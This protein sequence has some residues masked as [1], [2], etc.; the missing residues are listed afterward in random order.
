[1]FK[2]TE[3]SNITG[4]T[5]R[6][7]QYYDEIG[8]LVPSRGENGHRSYSYNDLI[9]V[10][11]IILLKDMGFKLDEIIKHISTKENKELK[12]SLY[13]QRKILANKIKE[14]ESQLRNIDW[15]IQVNEKKQTLEE[16]AIK[17]VFIDNN[18]FKK[19]IPSIWDM[20]I[21]DTYTLYNLKNY[22][23]NMNFDLYFKKLAK[24]Q[25][26]NVSEKVVQ[27]LIER[28]VTHL[29]ESY[30]ESFSNESIPNFA[31]LYVENEEAIEYLEQ[32]GSEFNIFLNRA[33]M[34]Y[35][36]ENSQSQ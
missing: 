14:I 23:A 34:H 4:L 16:T 19:Q 27:T 22:S 30:G 3:F 25:N 29:K 35:S 36:K 7:L 13:L 28:F 1:M 6:T 8:L 33:L 24:V 21:D 32:Y 2:I 17:K 12:N 15:L 31:K 26:K 20:D 5:I 11:E 18:P 9:K 10:H